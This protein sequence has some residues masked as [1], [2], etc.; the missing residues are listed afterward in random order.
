MTGC[1]LSKA[2]L[3]LSPGPVG[4]VHW[5]P[6]QQTGGD[7]GTLRDGGLHSEE[8]LYEDH[9]EVPDEDQV[10]HYHEAQ[11]DFVGLKHSQY[12]VSLLL[13]Y[14]TLDILN[15]FH[16]SVQLVCFGEWFITYHR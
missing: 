3:Q 4:L 5:D 2:V 10:V 13:K 7:C 8:L 14:F 9:L 12:N 11:Q 1:S 15:V 16:L 6:P